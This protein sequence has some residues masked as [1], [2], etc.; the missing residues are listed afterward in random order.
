[1]D[2]KIKNNTVQP[3]YFYSGSAQ[4]VQRRSSPTRPEAKGNRGSPPFTGVVS[5]ADFGQPAMRGWS[6]RRPSDGDEDSGG[7]A[8][9][10]GTDER[11]SEWNLTSVSRRG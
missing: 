9:G 1:L 6:L 10:G 5:L 2:G 11:L 3:G 8:V 4:P 7:E